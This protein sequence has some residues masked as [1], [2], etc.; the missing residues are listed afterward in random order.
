MDDLKDALSVGLTYTCAIARRCYST[1]TRSS[2]SGEGEG[3]IAVG[4]R[5]E[6]GLGLEVVV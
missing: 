6:S 1:T 5:V 4:V 3:E 2:L